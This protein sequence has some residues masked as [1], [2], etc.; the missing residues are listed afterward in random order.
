MAQKMDFWGDVLCQAAFLE[1]TVG[2]MRLAVADFYKESKALE[3]ILKSYSLPANLAQFGAYYVLC[4]VLRELEHI[5]KELSATA[6]EADKKESK[7]PAQ[8]GGE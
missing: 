5:S 1:E 8:M 7:Q 3:L 6:E 2:A 4:V